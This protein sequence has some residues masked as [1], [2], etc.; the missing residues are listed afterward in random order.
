MPEKC[1]LITLGDKIVNIRQTLNEKP[2]PELFAIYHLPSVEHDHFRK[3]HGIA[4]IFCGYAQ[5][6]D[7]VHT[8]A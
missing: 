1:R 7:I 5:K 4:D 3:R 2:N 8:S 6:H